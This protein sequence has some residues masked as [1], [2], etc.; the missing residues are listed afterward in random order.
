LPNFRTS[1]ECQYV[2]SY[3]QDQVNTV[4]YDG[5]AIFNGRIGYQWKSFEFYGNV[6][7]LTDK[8]Y[9]H[10]VTRANLTTSQPSYTAAA[11]RTFI[12][13]VQYHLSLKK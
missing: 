9:A 5:Y 8:L 10:N 11:P 1:V 2:S 6:M 3:F 13:G 12:F 7:N 4:K